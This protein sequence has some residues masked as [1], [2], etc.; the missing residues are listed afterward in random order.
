LRAAVK[1]HP[2][3][4]RGELKAV[5]RSVCQVEVSEPTVCRALQKLALPRKKELRRP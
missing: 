5:L 1:T 3:A 4:T 2:E